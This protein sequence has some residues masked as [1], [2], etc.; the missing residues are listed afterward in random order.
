MRRR[1][2]FSKFLAGR[3]RSLVRK[4]ENL[5][6]NFDTNG[7]RVLLK[8]LSTLRFSTIFDVG[9]NVGDYS[10]ML[11]EYFP[12]AEL[13]IFEIMADNRALIEGKLKGQND[14][15]I[16][17]FGLS[18]E[19]GVVRVKYYGEGSGLSSLHDFPHQEESKWVECP[20]RKGDGY[21][22]ERNIETIDF[23]K[24]DTE[25]SEPQVLQGLYNTLKN[26]NVRVIQFEYG[27]INIITKYLLHD[28]Y[29][30]FNELGYVVGK[31]YP[32]SVEFKE[33]ILKDENFLGPNYIAVKKTDIDLIKL[34]SG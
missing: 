8:K 32:Y 4:H 19:D 14:V 29:E 15:F 11:R 33:Y 22:S 2:W 20:V 10:V 30:F 28:F 31:V 25:G 27:Y 24:I 21:A 16:N 17:D 1:N 9:G 3:C 18:N 26:N 13:H 12:G 6:Y 5:D 34:L 7:E 23:L